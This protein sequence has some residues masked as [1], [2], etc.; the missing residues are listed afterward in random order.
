MRKSHVSSDDLQQDGRVCLQG[1][2]KYTACS[3]RTVM[4]SH[5]EGPLPDVT[6]KNGNLEGRMIPVLV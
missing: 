2:T 4:H 3:P 5:L 1:T 6:L